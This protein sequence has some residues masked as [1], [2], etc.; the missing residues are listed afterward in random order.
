MD[1]RER[2]AARADYYKNNVEGWKLRE[3]VACYG[4]GRYDHNGSPKCGACNGTGK[5]RYKPQPRAAAGGE[6]E[7]K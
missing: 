5:E 6:G 2:K 4:S 1:Y 7:T 3:C